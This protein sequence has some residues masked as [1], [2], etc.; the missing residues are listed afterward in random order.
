MIETECFHDL[1][2]FV[3]VNGQVP[4]PDLQ[5]NAQPIIEKPGCFPFRR[6]VRF[7]RV[8]FFKLKLF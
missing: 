2:L 8:F 4:T 5:I 3:G 1:N 7:S 6:K